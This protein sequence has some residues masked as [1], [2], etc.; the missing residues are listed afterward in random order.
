MTRKLWAKGVL[1]A[2]LSAIGAV[3]VSAAYATPIANEAG[4]YSSENETPRLEA[5]LDY[6]DA[7]T[8]GGELGQVVAVVYRRDQMI[9]RSV[10]GDGAFDTIFRIY[11]MTKPI[12]SVVAMMLVEEGIMGLDDPVGQY[13]PALADLSVYIGVS[14]DGTIQTRPSDGPVSIRDLLRHTSGLTYGIFGDTPVD[15]LY[16]DRIQ[17]DPSL[18]LKDMVKRLGELPLIADPGDAWV[19]SLST[20]VLGRVLEVVTGKPLDIVFEERVFGPLKMVDTGFFVPENSADRLATLYARQEDGGIAVTT[21]EGFGENFKEK[22]AF[23]SGGGGLV[24][25]ASDYMRFA[26]MLLNGG[27]LEGVRLLDETTVDAMR[28]DQL[29]D[30]DRRGFGSNA[31]GMGFGFGFGVITDAE[32]VDYPVHTGDY[33]W[34]GY[35]NTTFFIDP[36]TQLAGVLMSNLLVPGELLPIREEMRA[37]ILK[38]LHE[39]SEDRMAR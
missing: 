12:T 27:E 37:V 13:L 7:K 22:P 14:E 2:V 11:S 8:K 26:R 34:G 4:V 31:K 28:S 19:Y 24:S 3:I 20:D 6:A 18:T 39:D 33:F 32:A 25:T 10:H 21:D 23:L 15:R 5:L 36:E 35:A 1:V 30:A 17:I 9:H 38:S 29:G 16:R